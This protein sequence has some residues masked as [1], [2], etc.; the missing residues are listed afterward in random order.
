MAYEVSPLPGQDAFGAVVTGLTSVDIEKS[1]V[2][3]ALRK[4]WID[5]GVVVFRGVDGGE[6]THIRL[7]KVFG[8]LQDHEMF[9]HLPGRRPELIDLIYDRTEGEV[10]VIDGQKMGAWLPWHSDLI[11]TDQINRGGILRALKLPKKGGGQT[12]FIDRIHTYNLLPDALKAKIEGL[13]VLYRPNFNPEN[14]RFGKRPNMRITAETPRMIRAN[15]EN[16]P[17]TVH[18]LV[19]KQTETGRKVLNVSPWFAEAIEGME[20]EEGDAILK[21]V[22][23]HSIRPDLAYF[24]EWQVGDMVLWDNWRMMHSANGVAIDDRRAMQ[25]TTIAGDYALGRVEGGKVREN[26][27]RL[28]A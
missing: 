15:N 22:I 5:R 19:Y 1:D 2:Q 8:D 26:D 12:G 16:R 21:A 10:Y 18:P 23:E 11:Y 25:R 17:R 20:N 24:H 6:E 3:D 13:N 9:K 28:T 7:S 4:L 14:Q 27:L